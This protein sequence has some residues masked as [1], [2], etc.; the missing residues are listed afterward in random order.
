MDLPYG[1]PLGGMPKLSSV[2]IF[3]LAWAVRP[4]DSMPPLEVFGVSRYTGQPKYMPNTGRR[5]WR[6]LESYG[7]VKSKWYENGFRAGYDATPKGRL[8]L[9]QRDLLEPALRP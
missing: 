7:L 6:V 5:T 2:Q 8:W 3:A 4:D 1:A 9:E